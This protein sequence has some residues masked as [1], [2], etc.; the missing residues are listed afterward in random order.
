MY[1]YLCLIADMTVMMCNNVVNACVAVMFKWECKQEDT[2][3][4]LDIF[5]SFICC[6]LLLKEED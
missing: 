1:V 6:S 4:S 5:Y 2:V 3:H